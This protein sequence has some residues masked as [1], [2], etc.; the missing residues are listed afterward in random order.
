MIGVPGYQHSG[1]LSVTHIKFVHPLQADHAGH[2]LI[3]QQ[4]TQSIRICVTENIT[5]GTQNP[6]VVACIRKMRFQHIPTAR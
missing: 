1:E 3:H 6:D 4:A 2:L 5:T